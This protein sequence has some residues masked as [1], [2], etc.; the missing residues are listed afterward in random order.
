M[1]KKEMIWKLLA[2]VTIIGLLCVGNALAAEQTISGTV[3]KGD[4]G[5]VIS[6]DDGQSYAVQGQDLSAM[7]G[8]TVKA[9]G[10]LEESASGKTINVTMVE[11]VKKMKE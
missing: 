11:E 8:K 6:T 5:I 4:N 9:T 10:M 2:V 1:K 7:V 3:E